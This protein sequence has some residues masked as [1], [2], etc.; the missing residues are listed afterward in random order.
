[1]RLLPDSLRVM[2][3]PW[4]GPV[5]DGDK[6]ALARPLLTLSTG[7]LLIVLYAKF[8][9][10]AAGGGGANIG[11]GILLLIAYVMT[12]LGALL[13]LIALVQRRR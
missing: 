1:M 10:D 2:R 6:P 5:R 9:S 4:R 11:D 7:I 13:T 8:M 3:Q 12:G